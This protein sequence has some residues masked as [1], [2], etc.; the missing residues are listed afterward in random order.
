MLPQ[1]SSSLMS[2]PTAHSQGSRDEIAKSGMKDKADYV[3]GYAYS[4]VLNALFITAYIVVVSELISGRWRWR[5]MLTLIVTFHVVGIC[6]SVFYH[7]YFVHRSFLF[8]RAGKWL[9][10][11]W[12]AWAGMASW[13]GP[14]RAW[15]ALHERHHQVTD[16]RGKDPHGP[17]RSIVDIC[18]VFMIFYTPTLGRIVDY[19]AY[20][21]RH[22]NRYDWFEK[23]ICG[24][25][26]Y[27]IFG[28][29]M[30]LAVARY[31]NVL[32]WY[33][34]AVGLAFGGTSTVNTLGHAGEY[35]RSK[36][37]WLRG[38]LG[39]LFFQKYSAN[40]CGDSLNS[41]P[42]IASVTGYFTAGEINHNSH[43]QFPN[44]AQIGA[45]WYDV[46]LGW[47]LICTLERA[48]LVRRVRRQSPQEIDEDSWARDAS[49]KHRHTPTRVAAPDPR[50]ATPPPQ[51]VS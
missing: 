42:W 23:H 26:G 49:T 34:A 33:F 3:L 25:L 19:E 39:W 50:Q 51:P 27:I 5:D 46:D 35:F 43:H 31:F 37:G 48:K 13:S 14:P 6:V 4:I 24:T 30:P 28:L 29:V 47:W 22:T 38:P 21:K 10:R 40:Y 20:A 2:A 44:S 36:P 17:I 7:R 12:I 16:I 9:A 32:V 41:R 15:A 18:Y 45:H 1:S 11:P 8:T